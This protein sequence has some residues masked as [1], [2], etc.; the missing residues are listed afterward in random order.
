MTKMT[1]AF[2]IYGTL[3]DTNGVIEQ[4][5]LIPQLDATAF[6]K[7][8]R[9]KQLEYTFRRGLMGA[10]QSF[11]VCVGQALEYC[12]QQFQLTL[13]VADKQALLALYSTLP[14]FEDVIPTLSALANTEHQ[15]VAFSNGSEQTLTSLLGAAN[16]LPLFTKM[17]SVEPLQT[18]KPN[19]LVYQ[20]LLQ[21]TN[22]SAE[23]TCLISSNSF[24]V[25]GA[26]NAGLKA[27]WLNRSGTTPF[28]PWGIE[29]S[30]TITQLSELRPD[31]IN[32]LG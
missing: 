11:D 8:W 7:A 20:Y 10:Y 19:P 22:A 23:S 24:D 2:D 15:L 26:V 25:I 3:I 27:I 9:D 18:F 30:K 21:Q 17:V 4:L 6:A 16:V 1:L 14:A 12:C 31:M 29:P 5:Q 28:D 32:N 13:S